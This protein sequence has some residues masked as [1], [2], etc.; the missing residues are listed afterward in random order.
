MK[1]IVSLIAA[2]SLCAII[3]AC[4]SSS[5]DKK[6]DDKSIRL[7]SKVADTTPSVEPSAGSRAGE[8][9]WGGAYYKTNLQ[10]IYRVFQ[11]FNPDTDNG[12]VD[13]VNIYKVLYDTEQLINRI[14]NSDD[15]NSLDADTAVS[16]TF[17]FGTE[18]GLYDHTAY[19][20]SS[21]DM[22][23]GA[24]YYNSIAYKFDGDRINGLFGSRMESDIVKSYSCTQFS[25]NE[26]TGEIT[27]NMAMYI[28][29]HTGTPGDHYFV[30]SYIE[31]N[32][33]QHDFFVQ[34]QVAAGDGPNSDINIIGRGISQGE[35]G[36]YIIWIDNDYM[37]DDGL[38]P[39]DESAPGY[40]MMSASATEDDY[41]TLDSSSPLPDE[42]YN[43]LSTDATVLSY[44]AEIKAYLDASSLF[45][46]DIVSAD[47]ANDG[48][49]AIEQ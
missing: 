44:G 4:S 2:T 36:N 1:K 14:I 19:Q 7:T 31:G 24:S 42:D 43:N 16:P 21:S 32:M 29:Y 45:N 9:E 46:V 34:V 17:N 22:D 5:G 25:F 40:Y 26:T 15:V 39:E 37:V 11:R 18:D 30:R 20:E 8:N 47:F 10:M 13:S 3:A 12:V 35:T 41:S 28:K 38:T 6:N 33:N 49:L 27:L 23:G 48:I